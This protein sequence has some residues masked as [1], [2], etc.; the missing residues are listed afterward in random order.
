MV[1]ESMKSRQ[2]LTYWEMFF[3]VGG[4]QKLKVELKKPM[5]GS[6]SLCHTLVYFR[7]IWVQLVISWYI[8][9]SSRI[10]RVQR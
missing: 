7:H 9:L 1:L 4:A 3:C 10:I 5:R 6:R 8:L 2:S